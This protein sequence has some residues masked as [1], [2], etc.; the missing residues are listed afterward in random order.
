MRAGDRQARLA[1]EQALDEVLAD[2]FPASDPPSWNPGI[3]RPR[4]RWSTSLRGRTLP[5]MLSERLPMADVIDVSRTAHG[6]RTFLQ[7]LV[8]LFGAARLALLVGVAILLIGLPIAL[9]V[10]GRAGSRRLALRRQRPLV[11]PRSPMGQSI[12]VAAAL[13]S[14]NGSVVKPQPRRNDNPAPSDLHLA[15]LLDFRPDQGIIRLHEQRVVILS[16][17]AMGLLRKELIDTLGLETARR[18]AIRFGYADGYHD[19]VNLRERSNWSDPV[20]GVRAGAVLH[21]L[22]GIV[23]AEVSQDRARRLDGTVRGGSRLARLVRGRAARA[24]LREDIFTRLLVPGRIRQRFRQR[25]HGKGDLFPRDLVRRTGCT[26]TASPSDGTRRVGVPDLESIRADFQAASV[27][28]EVERLHEAVEQAP[29][30]TRST[31]DGSW[32]GVNAS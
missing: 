8:S 14:Y 12:H 27:G 18:V 19:A 1:A 15:E 6:E 20:E 16:A 28:H 22:E 30:G 13:E 24:S 23:R 25:V 11:H 21:T 29:Q 7:A 10:R 5:R 32:S 9:V 26:S 17:A 4:P 3:I 31:G 2:S